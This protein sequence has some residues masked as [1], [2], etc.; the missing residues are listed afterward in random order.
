L[1]VIGS[2]LCAIAA[3]DKSL[4]AEPLFSVVLNVP[5]RRRPAADGTDLESV[6][7]S[8][9]VRWASS[10]ARAA[11][12]GGGPSATSDEKSNLREV[13][14]RHAGRMQTVR[15]ICRR[16]PEL[17]DEW[18]RSSLNCERS[19]RIRTSTG[20]GV[21]DSL[22]R[23]VDRQQLGSSSGNSGHRAELGS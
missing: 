9:A 21:H 12:V 19:T 7:H 17:R 3:R 8:A 15:S 14:A 11:A 5:L 13:R 6:P 23:K 10:P 18:T 1:R 20:L 16:H 22:A 2:L 4:A